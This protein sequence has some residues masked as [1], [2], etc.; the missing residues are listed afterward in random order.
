MAHLN[1]KPGDSLPKKTELFSFEGELFYWEECP[2]KCGRP[3]AY[4]QD[5]QVSNYVT[6][7]MRG[8]NQGSILEDL[9]VKFFGLREFADRM[10]ESRE[11]LNIMWQEAM[12]QLEPIEGIFNT[13]LMAKTGITRELI[14]EAKEE[15]EM[16]SSPTAIFDIFLAMMA[17]R[18]RPG[19]SSN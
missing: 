8:D 18:G 10:E 16:A 2:C 11:S 5:R 15:Y 19:P 6:T 14:Q 9:L 13:A 1:W 17:R 4:T 3:T 12:D 7:L